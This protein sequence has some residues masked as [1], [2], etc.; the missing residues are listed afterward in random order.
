MMSYK[1]PKILIT[2]DDGIHAPGI[3][4]LW[5]SLLP[6]ADLIVVAPSKEQ[7]ATSLGIT[8]RDPLHINKIHW[9]DDVENIWSVSGTP[10]DCVKLAIATILE[11]KPDLIVSGINRGGNLGRNVLYS[12][13]VAAAIEAVIQG[14]QA[15]ALSCQ[16]YTV[17]PDYETAATYVPLI[18][19]HVLEHP[20]PEGTLL[21]VNF[22]ERKL[23]KIKGLKMTSQGSDVWAENPDMRTHPGEG[24]SYY[25]LGT[26]L[27][28]GRMVYD[29]DDAWIKEG[30]IT[31]VPVHVG[32]LTDWKHLESSRHRFEMLTL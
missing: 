3:R 12:G 16:D 28:E 13:T 25:W 7:S 14:I 29:S 8:I 31:A 6:H 19:Q 26:R 17:T 24:S 5:K 22:P 11:E 27:R 20:M 23:G 30:Y 18:V 9:S 1:R 32:N 10:A 2:N 4:A 15:I 21:N